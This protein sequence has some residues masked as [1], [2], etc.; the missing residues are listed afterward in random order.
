MVAI[1]RKL[2]AADIHETNVMDSMAIAGLIIA[3]AT[4]YFLINKVSRQNMKQ[5]DKQ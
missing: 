3:F 1:S 4:G 5:K 2:L